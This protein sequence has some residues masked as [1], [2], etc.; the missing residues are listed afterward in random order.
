MAKPMSIPYVR[1]LDYTVSDRL[2]VEVAGSVQGDRPVLGDPYPRGFGTGSWAT[3][4]FGFGPG[5]AFGAGV[6]GGGYFGQGASLTT[7]RTL[8]DFVAN[9]YTVRLRAVDAAGNTGDWSDS[10]TIQHRP[11][12]PAPAGM[13]IAANVLYWTWS[14]P[15]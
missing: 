13:A 15:Q 10:A 12:P 14:D 6:F 8:S 11:Q 3:T 5:L 9:D 7:H 1:D 2:Q 4:G